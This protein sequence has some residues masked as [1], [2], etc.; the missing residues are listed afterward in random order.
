MITRLTK[1]LSVGYLVVQRSELGAYIEDPLIGQ[2]DGP[3]AS[4][5]AA[6]GRVIVGPMVLGYGFPTVLSMHW[7]CLLAILF[8]GTDIIIK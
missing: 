4:W 3:Y 8:R 2:E 1:L 6:E 5:K 7:T